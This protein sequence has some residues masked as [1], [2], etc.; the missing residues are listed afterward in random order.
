MSAKKILVLVVI[1]A[2]IASQSMAY[3]LTKEDWLSFTDR[4]KEIY[5]R[6]YF[7]GLSGAYL[8]ATYKEYIGTQ[9]DSI[10]IYRLIKTFAMF[11]DYEFLIKVINDCFTDEDQKEVW[12]N[13]YYN[14]LSE[15]LV[16]E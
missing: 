9:I 3:E 8:E 15:Y 4:E 1:F 2:L 10:A 6:G 7:G 5:L 14:F 11:D 12:Y 16:E 13:I